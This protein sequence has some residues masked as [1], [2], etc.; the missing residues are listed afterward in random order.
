MLAGMDDHTRLKGLVQSRLDE[1]L[2]QKRSAAGDVGQELSAL[3]DSAEAFL[4]GGKRFRAYCALLG[5]ASARPISLVSAS[6]ERETVVAA[7]TALELFHAAAL[8]HDDIIDASETRR[9]HASVHRQ[10][11]D[12]HREL[13]WVGQPERFGLAAAILIGD[14]LQSWADELFQTAV[15][16]VTDGVARK[17]AR[18][19]FNLM[20]TEVTYGQY[21]DTV[22]EQ[23]PAF[24][25]KALQLERST[26]ILLYKTAKYS[27]EAPLLIGAALAGA[28]SETREALSAFALPAGVAFQLRDDILGVFGD[29]EVTGKPSG[30]DLIQ[31]KRTVLVTL[32]REPL[33]YTQQRVFDDMLGSQLTADQVAMMQRTIRDSGALSQV[34]GIIDRNIQRAREAAA[35]VEGIS[36]ALDAL[37]QRLGQRTK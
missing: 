14:L 18:S 16:S 2:S 34:E 23:Q 24:A 20:R 22:E 25:E 1:F 36:E 28:P 13:S 12:F 31:A 29:P 21:F 27:V 9:G 3:L 32:A 19:Q 6:P 37:A 17:Q 35:S 26:R 30:D 10:F 33:P 7:A 11:T 8:V 4:A 15:E 5:F